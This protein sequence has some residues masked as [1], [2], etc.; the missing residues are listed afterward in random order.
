M[1]PLTAWDAAAEERLL[2]Q[3]GRL[4]MLRVEDLP[5]PDT[6]R[7]VAFL[8]R[9]G[10]PP[11]RGLDVLSIR[12]CRYLRALPGALPGALRELHVR[13]CSLEALPDWR[14]CGGLEAA[15]LAYNRLEELPEGAALPAS[16]ATLDLSFNR[17]RRVCWGELAALPA[18]VE[19]RLSFNFLTEAPPAALR[20]RCPHDHNEIDVRAYCRAQLFVLAPDGRGWVDAR[21]GAPE[22]AGAAGW[23]PPFIE[24]APPPVPERRPPLPG[25]G[26]R[27][28]TVY[29]DPQNVHAVEAQRSA[30]EGI[31]RVLRMAEERHGAR[32][33]AL[34]RDDGAALVAEIDAALYYR[35]LCWGLLWWPRAARVARP[36]LAAWCAEGSVCSAA[37]GV[38]FC[39]LLAAVW[40]LVEAH[41]A[42]R[43]DLRQRVREELGEA[44]GVCFTGRVTRLLNALTGFEGFEG[45]GV[46]LSARDQLQARVAALLAGL[47][48][49]SPDSARAELR[50]A[51]A[52]AGDALMAGEAEAWEEALEERLAA[53]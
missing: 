7:F 40:A 37:G 14:A 27:A 41:P 43:D 21:T 31:E 42:S 5:E 48:R 46:R 26:G 29:A 49:A 1:Q 2:Q 35:R 10:G 34:A 18:L 11:W 39:R 15:D 24:R 8:E 17:L 45:V 22:P 36:P 6:R 51:L 16:L 25:V 9:H 38:T 19:A 12:R 23:R 28:R 32:V 50:A 33:R 3:G 4:R 44:R 20:G 52:D 13:D 30:R 47:G 53:P